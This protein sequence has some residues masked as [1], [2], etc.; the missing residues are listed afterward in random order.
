M[1][2]PETPDGSPAGAPE[3]PPQTAGRTR[4]FRRVVLRVVALFVALLAAALVTFFT[5]D[6]GPWFRE[7][8]ER[9]GSKYLKR[10]MHIGRLEA[11][12]RTGVFVIEDLVIEGLA[13]TD[14]PFLTARKITVSFPWWSVVSRALVIESV[15]MTDWRMVIETFPGGRH[16]L[17]KLVPE[18]RTQGPRRFTTT[19][20]SVVSARGELVYEDHGTPWGVVARNL[21]VQ[22]YR[23]D[24]LNDYRGRA[25]FTEGT[26][27]IQAYQPFRADMESRFN[28]VGGKVH[29]DRIDL[30]SD[31]ARSV[32]TGDVDL[33]RWPEQLYRV[34]SV[35][36]FPTQK[37][38]FF[39]GEPFTVSGVGEF[40]GTFHLFKGGRE[41]KGTFRSDVAGFNQWRFPDLR[42]SVLWVPER[43]EV[44]D[45][46]A[47]VHGGRAR[48]DYRMSP[49]G[50]PARPTRATWDVE[51]NGVSLAR[52]TDFLDL[53]GLRLDGSAS[54]T[55]HI[56]WPLGKWA[57]AR[58]RGQVAVHPPEGVEPMTRSLPAELVEARASLPYEEGPFNPR[59]PL[60]YVPVAG[61][62]GYT[63]DPRWISIDRSWAATEHTY[64]EFEGQTAFGERS[65]IRFHVTSL[66]WQ[67]SDRLLAGIMTAFGA[68]T[69]AVPIGG[70]GEF[71]GVM[72]D[73]FA[74]PRIQG[75]FSGERLR[76]WDTIWGRGR[77]DIVVQ[78]S[79]VF[80][81]NAVLTSGEGE[82]RAA[83]Q[84]SLGYPRRDEG[85][86]I[87]AQ[88][89]LVRWPLADLRHAF[90]LD[91]Y[92]AD[93][94]VSGNFHLFGKYTTPLG[95]GRMRIDDGVAYGEPFE[96]ATA[97]L[98]FEGNGVRL[99]GIDIVK[100]T[101]TVT[102]AAWVGWDGTYAF[103]A[104][105]RRIPVES[106]ATLAYARAPLTGLLQFSATGTGNFDQPRYDVK[107][108]ID[109]L[110]AGDEGIGTV[111][112]VIGLRDELLTLTFEA[113]SPRLAVTGSGRIALTPEMDAE[114]TLRFADTSL[115]PYVRFFEPRLSPF[116]NAVAGGTIRAVGELANLDQLV[117]EVRVEDIDLKLFDYQ[118]RNSG[119]IELTLDQRVVEVDRF[120][121]S[122][123]GTQLQVTGD[124]SLRDDRVSV[125]AAGNANLGILQGFF[126]NL[127]SRGTAVL[128]ATVEGPL[129]QP[130]F[131]GSASVE[132]GRLRHFWLPHSLDDINGTITF[133]QAGI[134][135]DEVT[136]TL[137]GG[138]VAFGGRI[139]LVGFTPGELSLTARGEGMRL[140]YPE[141]LRSTVDA[142][143]TLQGTMASPVLGGRVTIRDALWS[144]RMEATPDLFNLGGGSPV[145]LAPPTA[146][147]TIPVRFEV[148]V[149]ADESVR[150]Q[151]NLATAVASADLQLRG[152]YDR[153]LLFGRASVDRGDVVFEGNRYIITRGSIDFFNTTRIEPFFDL[154]AE[155][156][157]R[158][159]GQTY[160][161]TATLTGTATPGLTLTLNSD[162]PL[163]EIDIML[164]MFGQQ[165][166]PQSAE[167]R[168][169]R[170]GSTEEQQQLLLS[171]G[172]ARALT[173]SLA[174]PVNR[175]FEQIANVQITPTLSG[176][177]TDPLTPSARVIIGRRISNRAYLTYSR[178]LGNTQRD[179]V[180]I[181]EYDQNDRLGWIL[182][183][184]GDGTFAIDFRVR[185]RF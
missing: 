12:L 136:G 104:D 72:L 131:S 56:E 130:V 182:T 99:H 4:W 91:E 89:T 55:N 64:V 92:R 117:V 27:R 115:D 82:I 125:E 164:L 49:F 120:Q 145:Q 62:I 134:R 30:V 81:S 26:V 158:Q 24:V 124:V 114:L 35:I 135:L 36:D 28:M 128:R 53:Q 123:E 84:F 162:P 177:E 154:E 23:S 172:L 83:G 67:Q 58:W 151:N 174:A 150:I 108:G 169:L 137:G 80:V 109:D 156:R 18:R 101:A 110:F 31:G 71:D 90:E 50:D 95:Y 88:I 183:Q 184:N 11:T 70:Y 111:T 138:T 165:T 144:R 166:D 8:A 160:T 179:Q 167:L 98:Q 66:D 29:F 77:G 175:A 176:N 79:Y 107:V 13:P 129:R 85:D 33:G 152:T 100:S 86:E 170:P 2:L 51:Y 105:G 41:L 60:G 10:P 171:Q 87:D 93:G 78:N 69:G 163:S 47:Q 168:A 159:P 178:S 65:G 113:G 127:R 106:L 5:V 139:G 157:V 148:D 75:T 142:D 133:D 43:M 143:L 16:N 122:G 61:Q 149:V 6:I 17:P 141:G 37:D 63:V 126:R 57:A 1:D 153:P 76:A 97:A 119:V 118:L 68:P 185:A 38:I 9:E 54:G 73:S 147:T 121:L 20:R 74:Q 132:D 25:S 173:G 96:R 155:T 112:G 22:L 39:H 161:V 34:R 102:G 7:L 140:R 46:T 59:A 44:T 21:N 19:L 14:R 103:N 180:L 15:D 42:G 48:F 45:A 116:T 146:A 94:L 52:L 3:T 32:V 181:L 40:D